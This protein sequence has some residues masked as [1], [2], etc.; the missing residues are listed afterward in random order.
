M[1]GYGYSNSLI[2]GQSERECKISK[3]QVIGNLVMV[4]RIDVLR[5]TGSIDE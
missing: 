4:D 5:L 1:M 2:M 3:Y